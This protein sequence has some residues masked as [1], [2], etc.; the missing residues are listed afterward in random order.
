MSTAPAPTP[1][2]LVVDDSEPMTALVAA[3]L[4]NVAVVSVAHSAEEAWQIAAA[5]RRTSSSST[6]SCLTD[7]ASISS[8]RC[9]SSRAAR[10]RR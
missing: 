9:V 10:N 8:K 1:R 6:S 3:W 5:T 4:A 7:R 2:V